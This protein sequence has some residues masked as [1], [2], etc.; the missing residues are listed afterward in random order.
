MFRFIGAELVLLS[1][2]RHAAA[3]A[4]FNLLLSDPPHHEELSNSSVRVCHH[5]AGVNQRLRCKVRKCT[6]AILTPLHVHAPRFTGCAD[7]LT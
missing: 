7:E 3:V 4:P 6:Y 2:S 1:T 5:L